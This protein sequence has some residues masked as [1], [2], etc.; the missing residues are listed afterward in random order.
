VPAKLPAVRGNLLPCHRCH[1]FDFAGGERAS[2]DLISSGLVVAALRHRSKPSKSI[3]HAVR[4]VVL[5]G[6]KVGRLALMCDAH[7]PLARDSRC[8]ERPAAGWLNGARS[9]RD[10]GISV[11]ARQAV[12]RCRHWRPLPTGWSETI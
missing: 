8:R 10:A 4:H 9:P 3:D 1:P 11:L 5:A 7:P 6:S 2:I 12:R